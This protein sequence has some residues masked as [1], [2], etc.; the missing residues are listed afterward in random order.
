[1]TG[2]INKN[3]VADSP[4]VEPGKDK[5][6]RSKFSAQAS[7]RMEELFTDL[8]QA[9]L[10]PKEEILEQE[11]QLSSLAEPFPPRAEPVRE[12][13]KPRI[14]K[15]PIAPTGGEAQKTSLAEAEDAPQIQPSPEPEPEQ[16]APPIAPQIAPP[17]APQIAPQIAAEPTTETPLPPIIIPSE[18]P[19]LGVQ[20]V[21]DETSA[22][23]ILQPADETIT[24]IAWD[25]LR[26]GKPRAEPGAEDHGRPLSMP[27][28][29]PAQPGPLETRLA[30]PDGQMVATDLQQPS[31]LLEILDEDPQ[32]QWSQ[33]E[34]LL[35]EQVTNQLTLALENAQL[36]EQTQN[37]RDALQISVRYQ[38]SVAQAVADLTERGFAAISDVLQLL[39]EAAQASRVYYMEAQ[40]DFR[41]PYWH[42]VTEWH[43]PQAPSQINNPALR[44]VS[45]RWLPPWI[46]R[47]SK[48][49]YVAE[50][51][52]QLPDEEREFM[53]ALGVRSILQFPVAGQQGAPGCIGFE[54]IDS[55]RVW[56]SDEIAALQ[57]AASALAN[58]IVREN[59]FNQLQVNLSE[60]EAQYQASAQINSANS[61][62]EILA[63]L[64]QFSILGHI[65]ASN[66]SINLFDRP[67]TRAQK[68]DWLV[69]VSYWT[70][71]SAADHPAEPIPLGD[72]K[73][74]DALLN[75]DRPTVVF[76]LASDPR[77][78]ANARLLYI[79]KL[80]AKSLINVPL[81]VSG[82]W[83]GQIIGLYNQTTGFTDREIRR[84]VS[85]SGQSAVAVE[86]LRLLEETRQRNEE[87]LA[88]NEITS[89]VSRTLELQQ[90]LVEILQRVID[91]TEYDSG[92]I[93]IADPNTHILQLAVQHNF[94]QA[95]VQKLTETGLSGTSCDF[96]Y[97]TGQSAYVP[98]LSHPPEELEDFAPLLPESWPHKGVL[99]AF[100]APSSMGFL[101][102]LSVPLSS[103]GVQLGT[104]CLFNRTL[105]STSP[106]RIALLETIGQQ[107]GVAVENARLFQSTQ[108]AL[109]ETET[110]YQASSELNA[111]RTFDDILQPLKNFTVLGKADKLVSLLLFSSP[112]TRQGEKKETEMPEWAIPAAQWTSLPAENLAPRYALASF[113]AAQL[114]SP[115]EPTMVAEVASDGRLDEQ[116]KQL[117]QE[118]FQAH[119]VL[120][121]PLNVG[122]LWIGFVLGVYGS[123]LQVEE[124]ETRRL[125]A[126]SSQAAIA[127]QNLNSI[128][129]AEQRA[130][131]A[132]RRSQELSLINN[133]VTAV[134]G[135]LDLQQ[136]LDIVSHELARAVKSFA[137]IAL[138]N[139][140]RQELIIVSNARAGI[141]TPST[142]GLE[143]PLAGNPPY[144]E[145]IETRSSKLV[146]RPPSSRHTG[147]LHDILRRTGA[148]RL[149]IIPL[150]GGA[151]VIGTVE[152]AI[153][154]E[155]EFTEDEIRLA[156]SIVLQAATAI[157]NTR[158]F[159]QTQVVLQETEALYQASANLQTAKNN[160]D[161]LDTLRAY[162]TLGKQ[163]RSVDIVIYERQSSLRRYSGQLGLSTRNILVAHWETPDNINGLGD[164]INF[165]ELPIIGD[166]GLLQYNTVIAIQDAQ[167]DSRLDQKMR[168]MF[169]QVY[170]VR[171]AVFAPLMAGGLRIGHASA[172]FENPTLFSEEEIRR[173]AALAGQAAV[174]IQNLRLLEESRRRA[175]Q[176]QTAAEIARDTS[177][178]LALDNLL[179]R[180]VNLINERFGFYHASIFLL[181]E[182][183]RNALIRE[184][185]GQAGDEMKR[186]GHHLV[187]GGQSVVGQVAYTA[188]PL[189]LND[190]TSEEARGIHRP[191]P[192]LPHT[193]A[194]LGIPLKI[195]D[196]VIGVLDVQ[197]DKTNIFSEDDIS[198]LQIL[199]DQITVAMDTARSYE[200]AQ[201][202]MEDIR[203]A[204]RLKSQFLANMSHELRTPLNSII[205]F[206]RVI[207]KGIDGPVTD[208]QT[209]DLTAIY[210]S[211]QHLLGLINDVLDLSR[212]EAGKMDLA[213]E[214]NVNLAEII[215]AVMSTTVGLVKDKPIELKQRVE[216]DLPLV[217]IDP[218]KI[219]QVL[220]NL[221]SNAAKFTDEGKI[222]V[223]AFGSTGLTGEPQVTVRVSDTGP[224][225]ALEDQIKLF[226]PFSQVDGSLTRK[227]GGSGL[228][229]SI[230][231]HLIRLHHG[232]IGLDSEPG[233]GSTFFFTL[234][235]SQPTEVPEQAPA[236]PEQPARQPEGPS[237][238][239]VSMQPKRPAPKPQPVAEPA[240]ESIIYL[241]PAVSE[242]ESLPAAQP[243]PQVEPEPIQ[244]VE[245]EPVPAINLEEI[246]L[247]ILALETTPTI[248]EPAL[249]TA[250]TIAEPTPEPALT[251]PPPEAEEEIAFK[252]PTTGSLVPAGHSIIL[253]I[254]QDPQAVA[255]YRRYLA[256]QN[257]TIV[258][259]TKLEEALKVAR[260]T[261][262]FAI[263]LDVAMGAK[264]VTPP[265]TRG[266]LPFAPKPEAAHI[267][268]TELDGWKVLDALKNDP[269]TRAIPVIICSVQA[270]EEKG[271]LMGAAD[272]LLKP[273][274]EEELFQA[275][276][277]IKLM[278]P[279]KP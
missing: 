145:A 128:E 239:P 44:R 70:G 104:I 219:R 129:L 106:A 149:L 34:L 135:S 111:V 83:I 68:P 221:L 114:L 223:E 1:M 51:T 25:S 277:R 204:D 76:D 230:S 36:F 164:K 139:K 238:P 268:T 253:A 39:G 247:S 132:Q 42:Q 199:A 169:S 58:T 272:Y 154:E 87:L 161:I 148:N 97:Q 244:A 237:Q 23:E 4:T 157:Q 233:K 177:G 63:I 162:T 115:L 198:V 209:Q 79:D 116:A 31:L 46:E 102:Y 65:N 187:V 150:V 191:N 2:N 43:A 259:V 256:S 100:E 240:T 45:A 47:L 147:P 143:I 53:A 138:L 166:T 190:V 94:P 254:D 152:L 113:N 110:L 71:T 26:L 74:A 107:V 21:E 92:L 93:S 201:K 120:F 80:G 243:E 275:V 226:Q 229:L 193:R 178:T 122:G 15:T 264:T 180:C 274:L 279:A 252:F 10:L 202:A 86:S 19:T 61:Y 258:Q 75:A 188:K 38:K 225:I 99:P 89:S 200:I 54:Q 183:G 271:Y 50:L 273:I 250:P 6:P 16:A 77:L 194:E 173:L 197:S 57:T 40:V 262:P 123:P 134:T 78:D 228:G 245:P 234:P 125:S 124:A 167:S 224:G 206:S 236:I 163:P 160:D 174:A 3:P 5:K 27:G 14:Q 52:N 88:M 146:R 249:E 158:L 265:R 12:A 137:A 126:L 159:E 73:T 95:V 170:R 64:R 119:S 98:D 90:V 267:T 130:R 222:T 140:E 66:V 30:A 20:A 195:G 208:Q 35:I 55:E 216:P 270:E 246:P 127:A 81:N 41:G 241:G 175:S 207:L 8:D 260:D 182:S 29:A 9:P 82:R 141:N 7:K 155:R 33:D 192:L 22:R 176:L 248:V 24:P 85:L 184:S 215:R 91:I 232:K 13:P 49:G 17:I 185:T 218:M 67:W 117:F 257:Y 62:E 153:Q 205:G 217:N 278:K 136:G 231:D 60:T 261:Q 269:K 18:A 108:S 56:T 133:I 105:R 11:A 212:I 211:G 165:A 96:V 84:L 227:T 112:W 220:I 266:R 242:A 37:A 144:R 186:R 48:E 109:G 156:E 179:Q 131:E 151:E 196:L 181:D 142:V 171:S 28:Q 263:T 121:S 59:L 172:F 203:E 235:V 72:L 214:E 210:N 189:V 32:R 255:F 276:Q 101:S 118:K 103:K 69:P 251:N 168:A 213:I